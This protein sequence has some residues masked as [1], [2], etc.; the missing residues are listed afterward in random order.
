M[1]KKFLSLKHK[2]WH[3]SISGWDVLKVV[4][5]K[6]GEIYVYMHNA[7]VSEDGKMLMLRGFYDGGIPFSEI[8]DMSS[9]PGEPWSTR[10]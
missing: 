8:T 10:D 4:T 5:E 2:Y 7:T 6:Y 3:P 9:E 1:L